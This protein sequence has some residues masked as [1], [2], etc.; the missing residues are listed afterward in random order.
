MLWGLWDVCFLGVSNFFFFSHCHIA[1]LLLFLLS[2]VQFVV[3]SPRFVSFRDIKCREYAAKHLLT[4]IWILFINVAVSRHV[5]DSYNIDWTFEK[6]ILNFVFGDKEVMCH[7]GLSSTNACLALLIRA[8]IFSQVLPA[9][10]MILP[11]YW[12]SS[13]S[14]TFCCPMLTVPSCFVTT[15]INLVLGTLIFNPSFS[16]AAFRSSIYL[17][18]HIL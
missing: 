10:L 12:Y 6:N 7:S 5:S 16:L 18:T 3:I 1:S 2:L 14:F 11:R 8:F 13:T 9:L 17:A 15:F 4:H